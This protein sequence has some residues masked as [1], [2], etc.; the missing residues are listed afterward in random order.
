MSDAMAKP[1]RNPYIPLGGRA[2][3][4]YM[5]KMQNKPAA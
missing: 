1:V 2:D 3:D 5:R 4:E